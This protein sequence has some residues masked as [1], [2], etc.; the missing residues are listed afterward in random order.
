MQHVLQQ[1]RLVPCPHLLH[2]DFYLITIEC[3]LVEYF[4]SQSMQL[5]QLI[6]SSYTSVLSQLQ[7]MMLEPYLLHNDCYLIT[8]K[9]PFL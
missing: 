6:S 5:S 8:I 2:D 7:D 3:L 4:T 1:K 9:C